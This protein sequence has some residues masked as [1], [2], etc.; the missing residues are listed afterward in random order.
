MQGI[1]YFICL[2][3]SKMLRDDNSS[4]GCQIYEEGEQKEGDHAGG[5]AD[6]GQSLCPGELSDHG[7][8]DGVIE[9]LKESPDDKGEKESQNLAVDGTLGQVFLDRFCWLLMG[10]SLHFISSV[11]SSAAIE[12]RAPH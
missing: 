10:H 5:T 7:R 6:S 2:C 1:I 8:V 12:R 3:G 4:S 11:K 9:L